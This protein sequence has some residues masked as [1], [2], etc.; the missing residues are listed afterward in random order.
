MVVV[1]EQLLDIRVDDLAPLVRHE[2]CTGDSTL[3]LPLAGFKSSEQSIPC[4][5]RGTKVFQKTR[6]KGKKQDYVYSFRIPYIKAAFEKLFLSSDPTSE[7]NSGVFLLAG[8]GEA[9]GLTF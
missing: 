9:Q 1:K 8:A 7:K 2:A 5:T 4:P 6:S 3:P